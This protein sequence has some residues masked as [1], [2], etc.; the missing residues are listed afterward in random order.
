MRRLIAAILAIAALF[1]GPVAAGQLTDA[2]AQTLVA[3]LRADADPGVAAA[4]A[5]RN[6]TE[7]ARL[8]NLDSSFVVWRTSISPAEYREA[9]VWTAVDGLTAGKARIWDW[10][11]QGMTAP[12]DA[13]KTNIRQGI[14]DAWGATSATGLALQ[15][16]AKRPASKTERLFVT[17][18][19]TTASPGLLTWE[20]PLTVN[21][22]SNALNRF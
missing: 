10:I 17:G 7:V 2:Q 22:V 3:A 14:A 5:A 13:S 12:I 21:D 8:Y 18:T 1:A 15:A 19:G 6:D 20:G 16:V 9:I 11:T 4:L